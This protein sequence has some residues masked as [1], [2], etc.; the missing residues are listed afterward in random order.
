[1]PL[2]EIRATLRAALPG[3]VVRRHL[4]WRYTAI[5]RKPVTSVSWPTDRT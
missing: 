4:G 1:L 3:V 5:W 2:H